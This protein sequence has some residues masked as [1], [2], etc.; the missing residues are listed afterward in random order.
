[1]I[2]GAISQL[3]QSYIISLD[4]SNCRTGDT[5]EKQQ[6]Q[7]SGKD[8]VLKALGTAA[9]QLRRGLGESLASIEKYDAP[10]QGATTASLDALKAYS[11]GISTRRR[12]GDTASL[13]F[14]RKAIEL[15]P[16]FA[17]AHARLSTVY[18]NIGEPVRAREHITKAYALKDRVSEPERLYI[19]ARY[20]QTVE[21][22]AQKT[23]ETY[24]LWTQTYPK[25]FVPHSNLAGMYGGRNEYDKAIEEYRSAIALAPDEPLPLGN[26]ARIYLTLN[27]PDEARRLLEDAIARGLDSASFR[28]ELYT[29]AFLRKDDA[30]MS[31]QAEAS[32][33]FSDG[34]M[35]ILTTQITLAL[36]EG[37]LVRAEELAVQYAS[38]AGSKMGLK[39][40]AASVW[41]NV[42]QS[43]ASFGDT[44]PRAR[45]CE[46]RST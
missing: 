18:G 14:F 44:T 26:L 41:S 8:D 42:A 1:M 43:A 28:T 33:R 39:G 13:P 37:Q 12:Q 45:P 5:I 17:L 32:R 22:G 6:V 16:D 29:L 7:A 40:S 25:D 30:E 46:R 9:G 23:I 21:G 38:E 35:R 10:I 27:R 15:D 31:R 2:A 36:Y 34:H 20:Y 11:Q 4:A 3:G 24:Q 19:L